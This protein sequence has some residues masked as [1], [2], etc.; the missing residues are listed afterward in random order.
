MPAEPSARGRLA[1]GGDTLGVL[2]TTRPVVEAA[3]FVRVDFAAASALADDLARDHPSPPLWDAA[4]HFVDDR[5]GGDARTAQYVLV[6]D[7]LNFCFWGEPRWQVEYEGEWVNGYYALAVALKR[8]IGEGF[9]LLDA[10]YLS[11]LTDADL[12]DILRGRGEIPLFAERLA[13]LH[14]VGRALAEHHEGQFANLVRRAG[15]SAVVLALAIVREFSSF[16]DVTTW[17]GREVRFY[18]RAQICVAD[19]AGALGGQGLGRFT[20]LDRLTAF[21]DYKVPQVLRR[22]GVLVYTPELAALLDSRTLIPPG[23]EEEVEIRATTV[24]GVEHIRRAV[25][26][27]G[28]ALAATE[29]D[30]LLWERGQRTSEHDRPYH[31]TRTIYY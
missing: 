12:R 28:V 21:A 1:S 27:R 7:A 13:N 18:K 29:I 15:G 23:S 17:R 6:L 2:E 3:R 9:P 10:S 11:S 25:A 14:E 31:L 16:N 26:G 24:W 20:D 22:V 8:A 4:H 30:W 5:P 19:L